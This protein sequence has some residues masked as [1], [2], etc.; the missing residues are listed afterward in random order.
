MYADHF[1]SL[2]PLFNRNP[3]YKKQQALSRLTKRELCNSQPSSYVKDFPII[4]YSR[5]WKIKMKIYSYFSFDRISC[6]RY[7]SFIR[8]SLDDL[9]KGK[10]IL[11]IWKITGPLNEKTAQKGRQKFNEN[12]LGKINL[13]RREF[14]VKIICKISTV[15]FPSPRNRTRN[16][17]IQKIQKC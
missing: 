10:T 17:Q 11:N 8:A 3:Y 2:E 7:M 12:F 16:C 9:H 15:I 13:S 14:E 4:A 6:G 5:I 1:F